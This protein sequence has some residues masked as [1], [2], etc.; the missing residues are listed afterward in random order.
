[1]TL[2]K[3]REM[4]RG[5]HSVFHE[6]SLTSSG[7]IGSKE[8][9]SVLPSVGKNKGRGYSD[10]KN[11]AFSLQCYQMAKTTLTQ[12]LIPLSNCRGIVDNM[13]TIAL[14][15]DPLNLRFMVVLANQINRI[16]QFQTGWTNVK[17]FNNIPRG[18][19]MTF[20][21]VFL[22]LCDDVLLNCEKIFC[23]G[24]ALVWCSS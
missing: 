19:Y 1:M 16:N 14:L 12:Q 2:L 20:V 8:Q 23:D 3:D 21:P 6:E 24:A 10:L 5:F 4:R 18:K 11:T 22:F 17:Y 15:S 13:T 9:R 7:V